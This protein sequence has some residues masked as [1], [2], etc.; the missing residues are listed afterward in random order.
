MVGLRLRVHLLR[1]I[2]S[3]WTAAGQACR[4]PV[5]KGKTAK[6]RVHL[7]IRASAGV[8]GEDGRERARR[9]SQRLVEAGASV[10]HENDE[11]IG[12]CIVMTDPEGNEFCVT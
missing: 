7:D 8:E 3:G 6:N 9:Q 12:W 11:P 1:L 2:A 10:L 4:Q 5:P